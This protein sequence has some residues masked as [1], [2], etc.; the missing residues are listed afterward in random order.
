LPEDSRPTGRALTPGLR[1]W[2][3]APDCWTPALQE[4]SLPAESALTTGTQM[5]VGLPGVMTEANRITGGSSSY[6]NSLN[7]NTRDFQMAK[8]KLKNLTNRNQEHWAPSE[9]STPTTTSPGYPNTLQK[10]NAD[11]QS[12]LM[13]VVEYFKKGINNSLKEIQENTAK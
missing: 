6:Q 1:R 5:I 12:Y 13:K 9:P 4:E 7:I 10:Q 3:R 2:I 11:L 8:G